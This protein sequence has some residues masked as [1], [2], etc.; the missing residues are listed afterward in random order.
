VRRH[1]SQPTQLVAG[2]LSPTG[3]LLAWADV[4][5][6]MYRY[7]GISWQAYYD[8]YGHCLADGVDGLRAQS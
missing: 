5:A 7:D 4:T 8:R 3:D 2:R 6:M 1:V